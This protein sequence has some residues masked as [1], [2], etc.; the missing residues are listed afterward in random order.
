MF[1]LPGKRVLSLLLG[2][3]PGRPGGPWALAEGREPKALGELVI[4]R[5]LASAHGLHVGST[6]R[7]RGAT[8]RIVGLS[9]ERRAG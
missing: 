2:Y 1:R 9:D 3:D 7:H 6:L 4:D 5:V 8:L